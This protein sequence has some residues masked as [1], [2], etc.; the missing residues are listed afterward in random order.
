MREC[1]ASTPSKKALQASHSYRIYL[2]FDV[3]VQ[4]ALNS[5]RRLQSCLLPAFG[6]IWTL[7]SPKSR[8]RWKNSVFVILGRRRGSLETT[9]PSLLMTR[10]RLNLW[11]KKRTTT[12]RRM[13]LLV[14]SMQLT[15][16]L[17]MHTFTRKAALES[18]RTLSQ[19]LMKASQHQRRRRRSRR[20][21]PTSDRWRP[22]AS[23]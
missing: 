22:P 18:S 2:S 4:C 14:N 15:R 23:A 5:W 9:S 10:R 16:F 1:S 8:I 7:Q 20:R 17:M 19:H 6:H 3:Y 13:L 12:N 11:L 21:G